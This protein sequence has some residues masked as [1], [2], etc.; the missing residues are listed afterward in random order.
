ML[1]IGIMTKKGIIIKTQPIKKIKFIWI[2]L[3]NVTQK[4]VVKF[5]NLPLWSLIK[6]QI[7]NKMMLAITPNKKDNNA[8]H[9]KVLK[10]KKW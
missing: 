7:R 8:F 1:A 10:K 2:A 4:G 3:P 5:F 9:K 6:I